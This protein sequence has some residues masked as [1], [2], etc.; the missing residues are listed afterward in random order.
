[1]FNKI[2]EFLRYLMLLE[3]IF[4][5]INVHTVENLNE[6]K[7][8]NHSRK[9]VHN[10]F[11]LLWKQGY[12]IKTS[13]NLGVDINGEDCKCDIFLGKFKRSSIPKKSSKG[14]IK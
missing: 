4:G 1:M 8:V 7:V 9:K 5:C 3:Y 14:K 13:R 12:C 2:I 6:Y 10:K 11:P